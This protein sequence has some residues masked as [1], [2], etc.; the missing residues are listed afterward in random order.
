MTAFFAGLYAIPYLLI[1][2]IGVIAGAII[3][4]MAFKAIWKVITIM[5]WIRKIAKLPFQGKAAKR[6]PEQGHD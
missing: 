5:L 2:A 6:P 3:F 4:F 1:A